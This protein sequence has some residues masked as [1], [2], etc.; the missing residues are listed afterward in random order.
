MSNDAWLTVVVTVLV[1]V[2]LVR[3]TAP[4]DVVF[5]AAVVFLAVCRVITFDQ[6]FGGFANSGVL[7]VGALFVVAAALRETG[8]LDYFGLRFLGRVRTEGAALLCITGVALTKS[9]FLSNTPIVA[10][11]I[12]VILDWCRKH[13]VSPSKLLMPLS[14]LTILGGACTLIGTSTNLVVHGLMIKSGLKE[15]VRGMSFFEIGYAGAPCALIGTL[16]ILTLGRKLL[17]E[18]K[19]LL[20]QLGQSRREYL[21]EMLVKPGCR[22]IGQSV[23][24]AGLRR[25][26]GLFLIEIDRK[27]ELIG[28]V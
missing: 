19:E 9:V 7:L 11:L 6:A 14:F 1:L 18:R 27:G 3:E 5:L 2:T 10:I 21:V 13:Q 26:P 20:E 12:P 24:A 23:E 17:P 16:Y 25:L 4:P 15:L 28:P 22:L 8:V